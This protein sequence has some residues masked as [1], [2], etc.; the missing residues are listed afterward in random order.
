MDLT[1]ILIIGRIVFYTLD[2]VAA[3][4]CNPTR[5]LHLSAP[6]LSESFVNQMVTLRSY[7]DPYLLPRQDMHYLYVEGFGTRAKRDFHNRIPKYE[8]TSPRRPNNPQ[9]N[10]P[11]AG[12]SWMDKI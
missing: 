7:Q 2:D 11:Q 6:F 10:R 1:L 8:P 12:A 4:E 5:Q 9:A 3:F